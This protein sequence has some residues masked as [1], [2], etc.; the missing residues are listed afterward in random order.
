MGWWRNGLAVLLVLGSA[1]LAVAQ[2]RATPDVAD[3]LPEAALLRE[4]IRRAATIELR[5]EQSEAE[6]ERLSATIKLTVERQQELEAA[7]AA[8]SD[9]AAALRAEAVAAAERREQA[10]GEIRRTADR[11]AVLAD[12]EDGLLIDLAARRDVLA[13]VLGALLRLRGDP[14]PALVVSPEDALNA[15][16]SSL[17]LA[18]VVPELRTQAERLVADLEALREVRADTERQRDELRGRL[19]DAAD[20]EERLDLL[21]RA[22]RKALEA[23]GRDLEAERRRAAELA[24]RAGTLEELTA[25]LDQELAEA[26]RSAQSAKVAIERAATERERQALEAR[27]R[28]LAA[29][30]EA[31]AAAADALRRAREDAERA[32]AAG[33]PEAASDAVPGGI[34]APGVFASADPR[35]DAPAFA[36]PSLQSKLRLPVAG[37]RIVQGSGVAKGLVVATEA[38]SPVRAPADGWVLYVGP[39]R[40]YGEIVILNVG[41]DYRMVLAGLESAGVALGQFVLAGEPIGRVAASPPSAALTGTSGDEPS[42]YVELREG[43]ATVDPARWFA[44]EVADAG[45]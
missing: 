12:R 44:P 11:L 20:A 41:D 8:I 10:A 5:R 30:R 28:E 33:A 36:F 29:E 17:L 24:S 9:D 32:E 39:F 25:S 35:R 26:R 45:R 7:V 34:E 4:A 15:A 6:V 19:R 37:G 13:D 3:E 31:T 27:E 14:P 1:A 18:S 38:G 16:R 2:D 42:L 21:A 22:K 43:S 40:S 23:T